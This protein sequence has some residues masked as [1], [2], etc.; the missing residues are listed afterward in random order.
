M[1]ELSGDEVAAIAA[2]DPVPSPL[3]IS[4]VAASLGNG[5]GHAADTQ[6]SVDAHAGWMSL[7]ERGLVTSDEEWSPEMEGL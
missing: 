4:D 5:V 2:L 7:L 1:L 6:P 3:D